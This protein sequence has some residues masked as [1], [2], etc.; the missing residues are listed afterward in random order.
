MKTDL[1]MARE[2]VLRHSPFV[3][4]EALAENIAG[5]VAEGIALDRTETLGSQPPIHGLP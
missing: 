3:G 2:I 1:E 4:G 5:A